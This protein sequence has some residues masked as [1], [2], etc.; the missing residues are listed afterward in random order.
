MP[1]I[2]L[3]AGASISPGSNV[4]EDFTNPVTYT[5]TTADKAQQQYVVTVTITANQSN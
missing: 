2:S 4:P 3:I 1:N 5:I